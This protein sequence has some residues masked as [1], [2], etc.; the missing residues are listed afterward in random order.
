MINIENVKIIMS[1]LSIKENAK[2]YWTSKI[3]V[4]EIT[5][6]IH[7]AVKIMRFL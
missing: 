6:G 5:N 4:E 7:F 3:L 1:N 2:D